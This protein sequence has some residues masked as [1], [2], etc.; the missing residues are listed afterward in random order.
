[1][2]DYIFPFGARLKAVEQADRTE[3]RVFVLGVYASAV[4]AR[5]FGPDDRVRVRALAVASEPGIFWRGEGAAEIVSRVTIPE[6]CGYLKAAD[7]NLN[8]P[9]GVVLDE[10]FLKP[11]GVARGD[12]W[13]A[14]L[15]PETRLNAGQC[16]AIERAYRGRL[17]SRA[18]CRT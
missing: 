9:S 13:L 18:L 15:L 8:G 4:H 16:K 10:R 3:K 14:D 5:W 11:L 17:S 6:E 7:E 12:A 1:M 2:V